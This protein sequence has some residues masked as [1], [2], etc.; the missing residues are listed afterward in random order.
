MMVLGAPGTSSAQGE[1]TEVE[2]GKAR[3]PGHTAEK[4]RPGLVAGGNL[5]RWGVT[6]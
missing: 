3:G 4:G 6:L 2:R 1:D 5:G